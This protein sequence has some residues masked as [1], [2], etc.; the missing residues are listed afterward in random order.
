[1]PNGIE[2]RNQFERTDQRGRVIAA[3][4]TRADGTQLGFS[5]TGSTLDKEKTGVSVAFSIGDSSVLDIDV[6]LSPVGGWVS[7]R[8][9]AEGL[10][11][12]W[13]LGG[14]ESPVL[15]GSING[16][17]FRWVDEP[18]ELPVEIRLEALIPPAI[19]QELVPLVPLLER[20][21]AKTVPPEEPPVGHLDGPGARFRGWW[22][23]WKQK[24]HQCWGLASAASNLGCFVGGI[25]AG[26]AALLATGGLATI[27]AAGV[28]CVAVGYVCGTAA[29]ICS[30][31][32]RGYGT[33]RA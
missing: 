33:T 28:G 22:A 1:M 27:A 12:Y 6:Q 20:A 11:Y 9:R 32:F 10:D 8:A 16:Q 3:G 5:M 17:S 25:A 24:K 21:L 13:W 30:D 14:D 18:A 26:G 23:T 4:G 15:E 31:H 2:L 19:R 7:M 29:S